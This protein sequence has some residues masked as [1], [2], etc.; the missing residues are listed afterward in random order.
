MLTS[1][2]SFS[3]PCAVVSCIVT[4]TR[5]SARGDRA[6]ATSGSASAART[7]PPEWSTCSPMSSH[8]AGAC[9]TWDGACPVL[10]WWAV[11]ARS[12]TG[13]SFTGH[14][15]MFSISLHS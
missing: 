14:I 1:S 8:V 10:S 13:T 3:T 5:S 6:T 11:V 4:E 2:V 9:A 7:T 15:G 12:A